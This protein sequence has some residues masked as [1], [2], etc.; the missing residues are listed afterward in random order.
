MKVRRHRFVYGFLGASNRFPGQTAGGGTTAGL[1]AAHEVRSR[2]SRSATASR[3]RQPR[4]ELRPASRVELIGRCR[5]ALRGRARAR[6]RRRT[7][8]AARPARLARAAAAERVRGQGARQGG[9]VTFLASARLHRPSRRECGTALTN[10]IAKPETSAWNAHEQFDAEVRVVGLLICSVRRRWNAACGAVQWVGAWAAAPT[11]R[12]RRWRRRPCARS[13]GPVSAG[14][15][16]GIRLSNLY[17]TAAVTIGPVRVVRTRTVRDPAGD[18]S[19]GDLDG[20]PTVTI[21]KGA[22]VLS[23]SIAFRWPRFRNSR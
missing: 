23:D 18:R 3:P 4:A 5:P 13:F 11:P 20:K 21:A 10:P 16:C 17:G 9:V 15:A 6:A 14:R 12:A 1:R 22:D 7:G 8:A 19:C 2:R